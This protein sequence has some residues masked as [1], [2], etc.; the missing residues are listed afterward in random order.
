MAIAHASVGAMRSK[1]RLL[2][3]AS[4]TARAERCPADCSSGSSSVIPTSCRWNAPA[5]RTSP[6]STP[7]A[8]SAVSFERSLDPPAAITAR[9]RRSAPNGWE[10]GAT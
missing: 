7:N 8:W 4:R 6:R 3:L 2:L 10:E 9:R 5:S 1:E